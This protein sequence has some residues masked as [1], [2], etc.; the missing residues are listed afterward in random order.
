MVVSG[1]EKWSPNM[2]NYLNM[3]S[4]KERKP[5]KK[6]VEEERLPKHVSIRLSYRDYLK[7]VDVG[8]AAALMKEDKDTRKIV[9]SAVG[10][11]NDELNADKFLGLIA[12]LSAK[13]E[14]SIERFHATPP[15]APPT[16]MYFTDPEPATDAVSQLHDASKKWTKDKLRYDQSRETCPTDVRVM[17]YAYIRGKGL[18]EKESKEITVD[19]FLRRIAPKS[20]SKV[21]SVERK[22]NS[23]IWGICSEIRGQKPKAKVVGKIVVKKSKK[24]VVESEDESE[25]DSEDESEEEVV[26]KSKSKRG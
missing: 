26:R 11:F 16:T 24:T 3:P 25:D 10:N 13:G 19:K 15:R 5:K 6:V 18:V 4:K 9:S 21:E 2:H 20:L 14:K 22:D 12:G 23:F 8:K 17:L 1:D 7:L